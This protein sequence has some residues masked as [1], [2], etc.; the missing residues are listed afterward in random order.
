MSE[1]GPR[2]SEDRRLLFNLVG[3]ALFNLVGTA[4]TVEAV[5]D[6]AIR[7]ASG[8][9]IGSARIQ[10]PLLE[11]NQ[12][13]PASSV[14]RSP[15]ALSSSLIVSLKSSAPGQIGT[16]GGGASPLPLRPLVIALEPARG[17]RRACL[18]DRHHHCDTRLRR[19]HMLQIRPIS[20][21]LTQGP[22]WHSSPGF[23]ARP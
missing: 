4:W 3:T 22:T 2:G 9:V 23:N 12:T 8:R 14:A 7:T 15:R 10:Q 13:P 5:S 11:R 17:L 6:A 1:T 21:M 19:P 20:W 18:H 16:G